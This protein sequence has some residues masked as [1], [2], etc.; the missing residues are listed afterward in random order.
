M[1]KEELIR[2][3]M[4]EDPQYSHAELEQMEE[5]QLVFIKVRIEL[6]KS[7]QTS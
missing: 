3:I 1:E 5:R 7:S 6:E 2:F 4:S